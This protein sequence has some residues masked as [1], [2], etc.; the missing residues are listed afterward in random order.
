MWAS[1]RCLFKKSTLYSWLYY[2]GRACRKT[3]LLL[4]DRLDWTMGTV[5]L[6][7][8]TYCLHLV[9]RWSL[10]T[11]QSLFLK[12]ESLLSPKLSHPFSEHCSQWGSES[13]NTS[14]VFKKWIQQKWDTFLSVCR[15]PDFVNYTLYIKSLCYL[16]S[17]YSGECMW[18]ILNEENAVGNIFLFGNS[19]LWNTST[20]TVL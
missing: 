13:K 6:R 18:I 19:K 11:K 20:K 17:Q 12:H 15:E 14:Q 3:G 5:D 16:L 10:D 8:H 4:R 9:P 7:P 2:K 1:V